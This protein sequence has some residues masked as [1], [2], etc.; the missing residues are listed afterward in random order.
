MLLVKLGWQTNSWKGN[1]EFQIGGFLDLLWIWLEFIWIFD[2]SL[3]RV[4]FNQWIWFLI[5]ILMKVIREAVIR[6]VIA[7][8]LKRNPVLRFTKGRGK[9]KKRWRMHWS[10]RNEDIGT[11]RKENF[12]VLHAAF[13]FCAWATKHF[14]D[15]TYVALITRSLLSDNFIKCAGWRRPLSSS[16]LMLTTS[17]GVRLQD[18][19][20]LCHEWRWDSLG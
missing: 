16:T 6:G 7:L 1:L 18:R 10:R 12:S 17:I 3:L 15:S 2:F 20:K 5:K 14:K 19:N 9:H 13:S 11:V 8:P 4:G